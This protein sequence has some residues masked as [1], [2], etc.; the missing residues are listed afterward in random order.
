MRN[1]FDINKI[2]EC[3]ECFGKF[4]RDIRLK[5]CIICREPSEDSD[6]LRCET[7][8]NICIS[9]YKSYFDMQHISY[10]D[11]CS[12][13]TRDLI[14]RCCKC[15]KKFEKSILYRIPKCKKHYFCEKC[16]NDKSFDRYDYRDKCDSCAT[17]FANIGSNNPTS[18]SCNICSIWPDNSEIDCKIHYY[19]KVCYNFIISNDCSKLFNIARCEYCKNKIELIKNLQKPIIDEEMKE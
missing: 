2:K 3:K 8:R 11:K 19:C 9:C 7:Y 5:N 6:K 12:T 17:Y 18:L 13:L 15:H 4:L 14:D 16:I 10:C 1:E